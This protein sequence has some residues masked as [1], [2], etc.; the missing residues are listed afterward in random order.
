MSY[1]DPLGFLFPSIKIHLDKR[2]YRVALH[3]VR[4]FF[5]KYTS[6]GL[7]CTLSLELFI[8]HVEG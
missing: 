6:A 2:A 4:F 1:V 7:T 5:F 3:F 8:S